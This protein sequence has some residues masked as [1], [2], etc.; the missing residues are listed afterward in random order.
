M[1]N[2]IR[3]RR[4]TTTPVATSFVDGEPAWDSN[5]SRL[6]IKNSAGSMVQIGDAVL[7]ASNGFTG[8]NTYYNATGQ[9][10]GT[11][12]AANDGIVLQ[13]RAGGTS[14]FRSTLVPGTLT[15]SRTLTLPDVS[16]TVVTTGDTGSVSNTMLA[17]IDRKSTRLNSS[18]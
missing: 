8:A 12:T 14:S 2:T 3:L 1:P 13:G 17:T 18:H 5:N 16:G 15:A 7:S 9:T 10:F 6:F 11:A 4:G